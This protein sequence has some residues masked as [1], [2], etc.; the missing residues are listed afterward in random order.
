MSQEKEKTARPAEDGEN[1]P[2]PESQAVTHANR[3][4]SIYEGSGTED[5]P[6]VVG[7]PLDMTHVF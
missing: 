5:D 1:E 4:D 6:Y 3:A 7:I 2:E